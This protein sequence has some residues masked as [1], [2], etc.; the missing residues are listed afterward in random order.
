MAVPVYEADKRLILLG[1][2]LGA[3]WERG[4]RAR[5]ACMAVLVAYAALNGWHI[6]DLARNGRGRY[7]DAIRYIA[8]RTPGSSVTI[9]GDHDFRIGMVL[10][11]YLPGE[12]GSKDAKYVEQ[13][14]W[15][16]TGPQWVIGHA[17]SFA[18]PRPPVDR[19]S[20]PAGN[21]YDLVEVFRTAPLS[22]LHWFVF[23][24]RALR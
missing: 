11:Y 1:T 17:E 24:N 12:M 20:D 19:F 2:M 4:G 14:A 18:P 13:D 8:D 7:R 10:R 6:G 23:R 9:G 21:Q 3:W 15:P 16:P 5:T 22:G